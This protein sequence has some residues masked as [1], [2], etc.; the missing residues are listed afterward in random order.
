[1]DKNPTEKIN[2]RKW[3]EALDDVLDDSFKESLDDEILNGVTRR[4]PAGNPASPHQYYTQTPP[5][6][7][8]PDPVVPQGVVNNSNT[9][10]FKQR[11]VLSLIESLFKNPEFVGEEL[12]YDTAVRSVLTLADRFEREIDAV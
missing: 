4:I 6:V 1:M 2:I 9:L 8:Y 7:T 12:D 10:T 11:L 3:N 5:Y